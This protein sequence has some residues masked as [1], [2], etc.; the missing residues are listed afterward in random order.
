MELEKQ[1][2]LYVTERAEDGVIEA[3]RHESFSIAGT[4]WHPER[5]APFSKDDINM[6]KDLFK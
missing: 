5:E 2:G 4:M 6:V 3:I 1:C